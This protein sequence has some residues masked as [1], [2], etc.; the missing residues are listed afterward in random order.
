MSKIDFLKNK[1]QEIISLVQEM[2]EDELDKLLYFIEI[3]KSN[4]PKKNIISD[5]NA[6]EIWKR[7]S[8]VMKKELTEVS[9]NTWIKTIVPVIIEDDIFTLAVQNDFTLGIIE[10]RYSKLID[11]ALHYVTDR[12]F[13]LEY[14][15]QK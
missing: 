6:K 11:N 14:I 8:M 7:A 1:K 15:V 4:R 9:Y 10:G 2:E 12:D 13:T 5:K 3:N